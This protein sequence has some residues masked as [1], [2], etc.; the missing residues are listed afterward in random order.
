MH[1]ISLKRNTK[2][3]EKFLKKIKKLS[4]SRVETGY[5]S[6]QGDHPEAKMSYA[7]LAELHAKG[8]KG[9]AIRD[10]RISVAGDMKNNSSLRNFI[11]KQ[12]KEYLYKD[13]KLSGSLDDI[14][15]KLT[16]IA[17]GYFGVPSVNNPSNSPEWI[18]RKGADTPL[19]FE[20]YL[21][22][23]WSWKTSESGK[24]RSTS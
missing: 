23:A 5:F 21:M 17:Q 10:I 7:D 15:W 1:N 13:V 2:N 12:M 16:G 3:L 6:E 14:G 18:A 8:A 24:V 22:D 4:Q 11:S 9:Y 20:G 19:V